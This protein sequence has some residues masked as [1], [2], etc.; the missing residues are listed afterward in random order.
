MTTHQSWRRTD[1]R[2]SS[3]PSMIRP[4]GA[5][6]GSRDKISLVREVSTAK[7]LENLNS[8]EPNRAR[9]RQS[10]S[11]LGQENTHRT[12]SSTGKCEIEPKLTGADPLPPARARA[13]RKTA[14]HRHTS[15]S[16]R[17]QLQYL[18]QSLATA[19]AWQGNSQT[20]RRFLTAPLN[21]LSESQTMWRNDPSLSRR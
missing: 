1:P 21:S 5:L 18:C 8:R 14:N 9:I 13:Y 3:R 6:P 7:K 20:R 12:A 2:V 17:R 16:H 11:Q 10:S 4:P 15:N 19:R